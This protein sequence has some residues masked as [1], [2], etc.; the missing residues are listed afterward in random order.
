L[1]DKVRQAVQAFFKANENW[2]AKVLAEGEAQDTLD[3][4]GKP[5]AAARSLYAAFQGSLLA[6]RLFQTRARLEEVVEGVR[7]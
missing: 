6:C 5:E 2:L 1:P 7:R 3:A 4:G